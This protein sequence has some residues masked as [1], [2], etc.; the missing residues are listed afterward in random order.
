MFPFVHLGK[1]PWIGPALLMMASLVF[2]TL[3]SGIPD[4]T[5]FDQPH[6]DVSYLA[7]METHYQQKAAKV[8]DRFTDQPY[9]VDLNLEFE[10][11][12]TTTTTYRS[13]ETAHSEVMELPRHNSSPQR[14]S[15][16]GAWVESTDVRPKLKTIRACVTLATGTEVDR[17][18]LFRCL[19][20]S[21]G[22]D[23][24]RGDQLQICVNG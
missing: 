11:A 5:R 18:H 3:T 1:R 14:V 9:S 10:T 23:L 19:A 8:L 20:Y 7:V 24:A 4:R 12:R 22:I 16:T 6:D 17:D 21:L 13:G 2:N 15:T